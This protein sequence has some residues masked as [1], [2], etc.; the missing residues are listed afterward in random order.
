M[1]DASVKGCGLLTAPD[2]REDETY[3]Q[4]MLPLLEVDLT[5]A[6]A[7][8]QQAVVAYVGAW[9]SARARSIRLPPLAVEA[10]DWESLQA[11][12]S[13]WQLV[14]DD[15]HTGLA[16]D[17]IARLRNLLAHSATPLLAS[18]QAML[19][20]TT[21]E[22]DPQVVGRFYRMVVAALQGLGTIPIT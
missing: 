16:L 6:L 13:A 11:P 20:A 22:I 21:Q 4:V 9:R 12:F 17:L 10:L 1:D 8:D 3:E 5:Q 14:V 2:P 7:G 15:A 19:R 18:D